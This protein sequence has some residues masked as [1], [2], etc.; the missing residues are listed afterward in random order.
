[1]T[2]G[3]RVMDETQLAPSWILICPAVARMMFKHVEAITIDDDKTT[4]CNFIG[5]ATACDRRSLTVWSSLCTAELAV[6]RACAYDRATAVMVR[7][8]S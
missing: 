2:P 5:G 4:K 3:R 7:Q 8:L 1:M 6:P